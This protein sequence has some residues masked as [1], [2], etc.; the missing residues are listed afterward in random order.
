MTY[1]SI[2]N[3][4]E[5]IRLRSDLS[6]D[7]DPS[8]MENHSILY[9]ILGKDSQTFNNIKSEVESVSEN[10][11]VIQSIVDFN[12]TISMRFMSSGWQ[13]YDIRNLDKS[14]KKNYLSQLELVHTFK[15]NNGIYTNR[16]KST[17]KI[18]IT[19]SPTALSSK[20]PLA[21]LT[22]EIINKNLNVENT[23]IIIDNVEY[24]SKV[25]LKIPADTELMFSGYSFNGNGKSYVRLTITKHRDPMFIP[26]RD[27]ST[28]M[29]NRGI[30]NFINIDKS[31][32]IPV[33][34]ANTIDAEDI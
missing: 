28:I 9:D 23:S 26:R 18:K 31:I 15:V 1:F 2:P 24:I 7:I 21:T 27:H 12:D 22:T 17:R 19:G 30:D 33:D 6:V 34:V 5:K 16:I 20:T 3:I 13:F 14:D 32:F 29:Y 4:G 10:G 11:T 25:R 8:L